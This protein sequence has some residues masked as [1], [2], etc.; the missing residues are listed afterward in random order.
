VVLHHHPYEETLTVLEGEALFT[1]GEEEIEAGE[2]RKPDRQ[3]NQ[4][5]KG[6]DMRTGR[7]PTSDETERRR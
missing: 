6:A 7:P 3:Q 1:M 2:R 4:I 5:T